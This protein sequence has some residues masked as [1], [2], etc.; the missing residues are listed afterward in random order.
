MAGPALILFVLFAL[1]IVAMY[2]GVRRMWVR[3]GVLAAVG[4]LLSSALMALF[5]I[6][7]GTDPALAIPIGVVIGGVF[8][9]ATVSIASFFNAN[10]QRAVSE[11]AGPPAER[12]PTP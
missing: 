8:T 12:P 5:G 10:E 4:A 3:T 7:Q 11:N 1:V 9:A 6:A 2:L